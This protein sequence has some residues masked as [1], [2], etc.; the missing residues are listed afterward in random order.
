MPL[1]SN[2]ISIPTKKKFITPLKYDPHYMH[3][4]KMNPYKKF[5]PTKIFLYRFLKK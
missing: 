1:L 4:I 3:A 2:E 5:K